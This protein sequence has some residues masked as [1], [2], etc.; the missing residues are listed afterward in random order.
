MAAIH[1]IADNPAGTDYIGGYGTTHEA[2]AVAYNPTQPRPLTHHLP[3]GST[4]E[5]AEEAQEE[6]QEDLT[7]LSQVL[8]AEAL[9]FQKAYR[10]YVNVTVDKSMILCMPN[11]NEAIRATQ[12][13]D[14]ARIL[15]VESR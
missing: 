11:H 7:K 12:T 5:E 15:S 6:A 4:P 10:S 14:R 9:S 8:Q 13:K 3:S 1:G 2:V